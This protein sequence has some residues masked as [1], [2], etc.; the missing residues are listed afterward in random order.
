MSSQNLWSVLLVCSTLV[1]CVKATAPA[2]PHVQ[3]SATGL[4][5]PADDTATFA[6]SPGGTAEVSPEAVARGLAKT[7]RRMHLI[8]VRERHE[9]S[10]ELGHIAAIEW[11]PLGALAVA[12]QSWDPAEPLVLVCRSGRRSARGVEQLEALGFRNVAS[13]TGGMLHWNELGLPVTREPVAAAGSEP[14]S[15]RG[16][17]RPRAG[18]ARPHARSLG[19]HRRAASDRL[20]VLCGRPRA[21]RRDRYA[22]RRCR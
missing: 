20:G 19:A 8:D 6:R 18:A 15:L 16:C 1:G 10:D 11:V 22:W 13:M 12:S 3:E 9:L 14:T 4:S 7:P 17:R 2:S 5:A 21:T